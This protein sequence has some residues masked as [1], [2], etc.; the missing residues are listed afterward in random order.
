MRHGH[1]LQSDQAGVRD[2]RIRERAQLRA[3]TPETIIGFDN[4]IAGGGNNGT[5]IVPIRCVSDTAN[6]PAEAKSGWNGSNRSSRIIAVK[7]L[8][9]KREPVRRVTR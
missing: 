2:P 6:S 4:L 7:M 1:P 9:G 3:A 8:I 5:L